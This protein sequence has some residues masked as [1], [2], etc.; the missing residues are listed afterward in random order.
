MIITFASSGF[1]PLCRCSLG[2]SQTCGD[3][4]KLQTETIL[5]S[6]TSTSS[7][8]HASYNSSWYVFHGWGPLNNA[9]GWLPDRSNLSIQLNK[10]SKPVHAAITWPVEWRIWLR[11]YP[12]TSLGLEDQVNVGARKDTEIRENSERTSKLL[13]WNWSTWNS[14]QASQACECGGVGAGRWL[15]QAFVVSSLVSW[16]H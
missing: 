16:S 12:W 3:N 10:R 8:A 2:C 15:L 6:R 5:L 13:V 14:I 9:A 11:N 4:A 7:V 1:S